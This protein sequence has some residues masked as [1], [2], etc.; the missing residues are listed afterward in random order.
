MKEL[1]ELKKSI[2]TWTL[3][4]T[5]TKGTQH[6]LASFTSGNLQAQLM[7][8]AARQV[9]KAKMLDGYIIEAPEG[10]TERLQKLVPDLKQIGMDADGYPKLAA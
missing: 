2:A 9:V 5:D 1:V 3:M 8:A 6:V 10:E 7:I 4:Y